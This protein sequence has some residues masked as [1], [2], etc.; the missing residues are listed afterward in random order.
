MF[1][2][3]SMDKCVLD[4]SDVDQETMRSGKRFSVFNNLMLCLCSPILQKGF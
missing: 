2:F 1:Y 4:Q 3:L